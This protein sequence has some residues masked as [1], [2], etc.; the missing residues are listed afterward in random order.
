MPTPLGSLPRSFQ[1]DIF[2]TA[3]SP[4]YIRPV[5]EARGPAPTIGASPSSFRGHARGSGPA[6]PASS[7]MKLW[8]TNAS[9]LE[10]GARIGPVGTPSDMVDWSILQLATKRAGNSL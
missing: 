6:A 1:P 7:S 10:P 5:L 4:P 8:F 3:A 9:A 2:S